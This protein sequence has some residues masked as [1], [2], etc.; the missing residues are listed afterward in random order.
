ME[1]ELTVYSCLPEE[2]ALLRSQAAKKRVELR[3]TREPLTLQN[4]HWARGTVSISHRDSVD[5]RALKAL[6]REGIC[7]LCT[8][9]VGTDHIDLEAAKALG[10]PVFNTPYSPEGVAD[11]TLFLLLAALRGAPGIFRRTR[12]G[13]FSLPGERAKEMHE[14]CIGV[15]GAG[16]IGRAVI[17]R[18]EGFGCKVRIADPG[19][20]AGEHPVSLETLLE[21]C[22]GLTLHL[23]LTPGTRHLLGEKEFQMMRPGTIL[24]NTAR[25]GLVDTSALLRALDSGRCGFAALDVVEEEK[26]VFGHAVRREALCAPLAA[27]AGH[28]R[29]LLSPHIAYYTLPGLRDTVERAIAIARQGE[30]RLEKWIV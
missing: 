24:V 12:E 19:A 14:M 21:T 7:A 5:A 16:R 6:S 20:D 1:Y 18:L 4:A 26:G 28:P 15:V 3:L 25:G 13:N 2:E 11:Y 30:G 27:L 9:S 22:D 8:R 29:V 10:I 23:P 17:R